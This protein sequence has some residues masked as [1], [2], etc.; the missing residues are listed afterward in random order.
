MKLLLLLL[1]ALAGVFLWRL[2]RQADVKRHSPAAGSD[3]S[4]QDMVR[5]DLCALHVPLSDAVQGRSGRYCCTEH[6][7]RAE[8]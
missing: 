7:R 4:A 6:L 5:C 8:P 2:N 1:L 3:G